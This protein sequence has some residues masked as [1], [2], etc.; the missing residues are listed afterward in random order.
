MIEPIDDTPVVNRATLVGSVHL[1]LVRTDRG[2]QEVLMMRRFNTGYA[3]GN[4]SVPAGHIDPGESA[5]AA[6]VREAAE[7]IGILVHP[8]DLELVHVMHRRSVGTDCT[9]SERV[10]FFFEAARQGVTPRNTEPHKCDDL[11]W[12][13]VTELPP[14]TVEYVRHAIAYCLISDRYSEQGWEAPCPACGSG[15]GHGC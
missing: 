8:D 3:D 13:P 7:E 11:Q 5:T 9:N 10:D 15:G 12:F 6:M 1:L 2:A 4:Y 14:N